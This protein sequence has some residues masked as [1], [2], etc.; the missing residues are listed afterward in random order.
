MNIRLVLFGLMSLF[1][2]SPIFSSDNVT[3]QKREVSTA[4]TGIEEN[5]APAK[6]N[7]FVFEAR[8]RD[9]RGTYAI[10]HSLSRPEKEEIYAAWQQG[11]SISQLRERITRM[12]LN[13][14]YEKY[15]PGTKM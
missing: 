10:Y 6:S 5:D 13:H 14:H 11:E 3:G 4:S 1:W 2:L 12:R 15:L 7:I 8:L 9:Y